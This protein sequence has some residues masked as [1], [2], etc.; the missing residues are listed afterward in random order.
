LDM[1]RAKLGR[2]A[3]SLVIRATLGTQEAP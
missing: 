1:L 3:H 2:E